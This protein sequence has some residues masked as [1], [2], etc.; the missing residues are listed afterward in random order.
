MNKALILGSTGL[1]GSILLNELLNSGLYSEVEIWVRK[2]T[3]ITHPNVTE[4]IVDF[5]SDLPVMSNISDVYC[6][7]GTTIKKAGTKEKFRA[8]D[9]DLVVRCAKIASDSG[10][11]SFAVM[12]SIGANKNSS[13]NYLKVKGE[14]EFAVSNFKIPSVIIM[15][16]SIILGDRKEVRMFEKGGKV[17]M[18]LLKPF[19]IGKIR[20]YRAIHAQT[21]AKSMILLT[22]QHT[23]CVRILESDEIQSIASK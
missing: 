21:I 19:L 22:Q 6:C 4:I 11:R 5:E 12:S 15:R 3:G 20:K 16:P 8:I 1:T 2:S 23:I 13:N 10:V 17:F 9:H 18:R 7:I 14:M